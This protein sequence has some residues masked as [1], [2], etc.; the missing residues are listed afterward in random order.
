MADGLTVLMRDVA[1]V[2]R[3]EYIKAELKHY[4]I[5]IECEPWVRAEDG[6]LSMKTAIYWFDAAG[7]FYRGR[8]TLAAQGPHGQDTNAVARE[9]LYNIGLNH[10]LKY[11]NMLCDQMLGGVVL[12]LLPP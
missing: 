12:P 1:Q 10:G 2:N 8:Y 7:G 11:W 6:T 4:R 5:N 9:L 3:P